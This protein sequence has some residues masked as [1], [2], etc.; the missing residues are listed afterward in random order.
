V[1]LLPLN[2]IVIGDRLREADP[3]KVAQLAAD[4]LE[5]GLLH[6]IVVGARNGCQLVCGLHRYGAIEEIYR[7][8]KQFRHEEHMVPRGMIPASHFG[9]LTAE[10]MLKMEIVENLIR[11]EL[12]WQEKTR[13]LSLIHKEANAGEARPN[14]SA[15]A[16]ALISAGEKRDPDTVRKE[17]Q[18]AAVVAEHLHDP[19]VAKAKTVSEAYSI[20]S[21]NAKGLA[22]SL[23]SK[24]LTPAESIHTLIEGDFRDHHEIL[25]E[26]Q[27][28]L[29]LCDP[30][31]GAEAD[32]WKTK[33][34]DT[35]H[36]YD[37]SLDH[38]LEIY[39]AI[40]RMGFDWTAA[41]ANLFMFCAPQYWHLLH[42]LVQR[43]GWAPWARPIIWKKSNEGIRPHGQLGFAYTYETILY[44]TKGGMGLLR[45]ISDVIEVYKVSTAV[46][47]HGAQ[48]PAELYKQLIDITCRA[49]DKIC[50]PTA[51]SGTIF[52]AAS[53]TGTIATGAE[54]NPE[55][56]QLC[57]NRIAQLSQQAS[58]EEEQMDIED[59]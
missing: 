8:G 27:F 56:I 59:L 53:L 17:V 57:R 30:P 15:T 35:P 50:D 38:A 40:S 2:R 13:M 4:I 10:Q 21:K 28:N 43:D 5:N 33:F 9:E 29:V 16:R 41:R 48:K 32:K 7:Q 14:V 45:S 22:A 1:N 3:D 24:F 51:G 39:S 31:Y 12:T 44:A 25:R 54:I 19:R 58:P 52:E 18:K 23:A 36:E 26:E 11:N 42:K 37:D 46:R 20:I 34:R 55:Y 47:L 6:P 49:G